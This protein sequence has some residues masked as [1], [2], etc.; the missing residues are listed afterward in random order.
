MHPSEYKGVSESMVAQHWID[1]IEKIFRNLQSED[2]EKVWLATHMPKGEADTWWGNAYALMA[3]QWTPV[4][5]KNFRRMFLD[6]FF[7]MVMKTEKEE[8]FLTLK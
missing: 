1:K 5:W 2:E 7:P 6:Q 4:T 8:E 3:T